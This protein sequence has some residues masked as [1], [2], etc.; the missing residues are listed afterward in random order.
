MAVTLPEALF[1]AKPAEIKATSKGD[2]RIQ[3]VIYHL[4]SRLGCLVQMGEREL[5]QSLGLA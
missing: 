3:I 2:H 4:S 1:E 5:A